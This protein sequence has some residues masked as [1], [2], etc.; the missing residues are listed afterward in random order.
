M[1]ILFIND[2]S[3]I[4]C[5][6]WVLRAIIKEICDILY[7]NGSNELADWLSSEQSPVFLY[8]HL[9]VRDLT[10]KNQEALINAIIPAF[11]REKERGPINWQ[12]TSYW[13]GYINLFENLAKQIE[14][15]SQG[16]KPSNLANLNGIAVH[17]GIRSGPGWD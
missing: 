17:T 11:N 5:A 6:G 12:D 14:E 7:E 8:S 13:D 10:Q 3:G 4:G 2:E 9:D 1:G 15:I 16:Q